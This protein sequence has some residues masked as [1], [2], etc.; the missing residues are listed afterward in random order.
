MGDARFALVGVIL[1]AS[2]A[3]ARTLDVET[4]IALALDHSHQVKAAEHGEAKARAELAEAFNQFFPRVSA[5]ASY[6]RL[7]QVP[8]VAFD[9]SALG[10]GGD[11]CSNIDPETLPAGWT[12]EMAEDFCNLLMGWLAPAPDPDNPG[13]Q[14]ALGVKDNF[15]VRLSAEQVLFAG[16]ALLQSHAAQ[17]DLHHA[18]E[19]QI[20]LARQEVAYAAERSFYQLLAARGAVRVTS[21]AEE[22][23]AAYVDDLQ[24]MVDVGMGSK[25]DLLAAQ[26]QFSQAR[27]DA[28]RTA[29]AAKLAESAFKVSLGLP[30]DE[31]LELVFEREA[32]PQPLDADPKDLLVEALGN[33]PDLA[34]LDANVAALKHFSGAAWASWLPSLAVVGNVNFKNPNYALEPEW[35]TS[36]DVTLAASWTLWDRGKGF[37]GN[38]A[39]RAGAA[40]LHS[41]RMLLAE[42][43][44]VEVEQAVTTLSEAVAE[45]DVARL[46]VE[47]ATEALRLEQERFEAGIANNTELLRA[48]SALS[49]AR[50]SALQAEAAVYISRAA[51]DKAIG[52]DPETP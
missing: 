37:Y 44:A 18:S 5:S 24:A 22:T 1:L 29:H 10:G 20:R 13:N 40:Q 7:D 30:A 52:V 34:A 27:L 50:L 2:P 12:P 23:V 6:T 11:Q 31:T 9:T 28:M 42:M 41:Q 15:S 38:R 43:M 3:Q 19:E 46:G 49:G 36:A 14:I 8:Y 39:A 48:Q 4:A 26:A 25:A 51:V 45:L 21:E 32:N 17:K 33:R 47:A 16:G 35:F